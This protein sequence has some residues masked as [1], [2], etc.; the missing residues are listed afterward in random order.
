VSFPSISHRELRNDSG[1]I[2][3]AVAEGESFVITNNGVGV[4]RITPLDAAVARQARSSPGTRTRFR[5]L[6]P[7]DVD[8]PE[9]VS[10]V[11]DY[12]RGDR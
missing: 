1:R 2:L 10:E 8:D 12:L 11:L 6:E 3:R 5:D 7:C 4:A 9:S